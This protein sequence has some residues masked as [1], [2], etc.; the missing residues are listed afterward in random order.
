MNKIAKRF[1]IGTGIVA[2]VGI[3]IGATSGGH[4]APPPAPLGTVGSAVSSV[5]APPAAAGLPSTRA[6][7]G[8]VTS[9]SD[10]GTYKV[11]VDIAAGSYKGVCVTYGYWEREKNDSGEFAAIIANDV[12]YKP[13]SL[14]V[15][16][17]NGEFLKVSGDC[18]WTRQ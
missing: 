18:T 17:K 11:G 3:V 9:F 16:V 12:I 10:P 2:V 14:R 15:T 13:G 6:L 8:P 4:N 5:G 7:A 1:L